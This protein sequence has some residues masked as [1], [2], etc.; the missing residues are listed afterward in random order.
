MT[1]WK[2]SVPNLKQK[3]LIFLIYGTPPLDTIL[4]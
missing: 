2:D 3:S 1:V 4:I